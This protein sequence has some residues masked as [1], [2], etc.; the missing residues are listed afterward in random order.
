MEAFALGVVS[1]L[2]ASA[3]IVVLGWF[4]PRKV[5]RYTVRVLSRVTGVGL[6]HTYPT[7]KAA[8]M[9]LLS[10]LH[11]ARWAKVLVGRG[12]EL[13]RD[14]FHS[15]WTSQT[16]KLKH[17]YILL[18]DPNSGPDSWL[19]Q[20]EAEL[21]LFD[22]GYGSGLLARQI[23]GNLRYLQVVSKNIK[24]VEIRLYDAPNTCRVIV[25]DHVAYFTPYSATEHGRNSPCYVFIAGTPLYDF[26]L[27]VFDTSWE[28]ATTPRQEEP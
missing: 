5:K 8:N 27:R 26:F 19:A 1:S 23:L 28:R 24:G 9:D 21:A 12:N 20:R 7:Q 2:A 14:S 6:R 13:T 25:T 22:S 11:K 15:V 18:P 10:E 4:G 3:L 16:R 17:V